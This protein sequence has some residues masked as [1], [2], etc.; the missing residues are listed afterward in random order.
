MT[1]D[2]IFRFYSMTKP[3]TSVALMMLYEQGR[4]R[5]DDP[6][7]TLIPSFADLR[8]YEGGMFDSVRTTF[9]DREMQIRDLLTHTSGLTY[10]FMHQHPVDALYREKKIGG[11]FEA[12]NDDL[13]TMVDKLSQIPLLFSPGTEWSYSVASD[14]C[15]HLVELI[16]GERFDH[17]LQNRILA[18]LGMVDTGFSVPDEQIDRFAACYLP[19]AGRDGMVLFDSPKESSYRSHPVLFSGGGGLVSTASDYLRFCTMLL[20]GGEL[21]G[22]RVLGRK[23]VDYMTSNHLAG[24]TDLAGMGQPVF[25][26][27]SY[28]GIGVGLGFSVMLDP[29][30]A[31]VIGSPGEYGW[32]GA[33]STMFWIDPAEELIAMF[34][35]QL[36]PSS[37]YPVR[38][39]MK[40]LT[41]QALVD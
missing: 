3:I 16:S 17:F 39:Q 29:A 14:V 37:T 35:T 32:G 21:D 5:L 31:A 41:Y 22:T 40:A 27:T 1:E 24:G 34:L 33:A 11:G 26:E 12:V 23:T 4:F 28:E 15:G 9:P 30:R 38:P 10:D 18:P 13:A 20:N 36:V 19:T 2:T 6:V 25:T 8:V 7:S